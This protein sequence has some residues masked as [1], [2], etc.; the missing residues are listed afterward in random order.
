MWHGVRASPQPRL[1]TLGCI[2]RPSAWVVRGHF[3]LAIFLGVQKWWKRQYVGEKAA[4]HN[5]VTLCDAGVVS[6]TA[7]GNERCEDIARIWAPWQL[8][9][10]GPCL[11]KKSGQIRD[12][13]FVDD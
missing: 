7:A 1:T 5:H 3:G 4:A 6:K 8:R 11:V 10:K 2:A 13:T 12:A 9:I